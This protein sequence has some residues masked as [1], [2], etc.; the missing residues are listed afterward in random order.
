MLV[1]WIAPVPVNVEHNVEL[2]WT[3]F[4]CRKRWLKYTGSPLS[5]IEK[6]EF[7]NEKSIDDYSLTEFKVRR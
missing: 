4:Y 2:L 5:K 1:N 7:R 3:V 6:A